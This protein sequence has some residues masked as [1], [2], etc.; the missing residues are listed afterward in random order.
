MTGDQ[1]R[2]LKRWPLSCCPTLRTM[3]RVS[4][5]EI[6]QGKGPMEGRRVTGYQENLRSCREAG[7]GRALGS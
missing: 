6:G 3:D 1:G 2:P 7:K 4:G 5:R